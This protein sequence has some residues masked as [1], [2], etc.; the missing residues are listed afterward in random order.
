MAECKERRQIKNTVQKGQHGRERG[1]GSQT[2]EGEKRKNMKQRLRAG[3]TERN[4]G[5]EESEGRTGGLILII[6]TEMLK[7]TVF[8]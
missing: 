6:L 8:G 2:E 7:N 3:E 5:R 4:R 1:R